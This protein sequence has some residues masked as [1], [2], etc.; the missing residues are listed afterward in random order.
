MKNDPVQ[1]GLARLDDLPLRTPEGQKQIAKA[2]ASKSNLIVAKAARIASDAQWDE[3]TGELAAALERF[4]KRAGE[5]DKG[6]VAMTAIA[7]ARLR[8]CGVVSRRHA[9]HTNRTGVGRRVR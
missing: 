2:L 7:R 6:C 8:R 9:P 1:A 4:L 5:G 3:L